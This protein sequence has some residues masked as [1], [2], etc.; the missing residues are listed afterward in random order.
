ML[1]IMMI[2]GGHFSTLGIPVP[3]AFFTPSRCSSSVMAASQAVSALSTW[4]THHAVGEPLVVLLMWDGLFGSAQGLNGVQRSCIF[5]HE[6]QAR[7]LWETSPWHAW[8][9]HAATT[10]S[11]VTAERFAWAGSVTFIGCPAWLE[12]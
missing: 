11:A 4:R 8:G 12:Y 2:L 3:V 6:Q 10:Y 7:S 1:C 9:L 5:E